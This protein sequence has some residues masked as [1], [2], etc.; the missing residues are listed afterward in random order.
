M[1]K[2]GLRA[3]AC[4]GAC[5][6][7]GAGSHYASRMC[8]RVP[9]TPLCSAQVAMARL[10]IKG[11]DYGPHAF[12]LPIRD[13]ATHEPLP[14]IDVGD[15]GPK[16]GY[17]GVDNGYVRPARAAR[18]SCGMRSAAGSMSTGAADRAERECLELSFATLRASSLIWPASYEGCRI[19]THSGCVKVADGALLEGVLSGCCSTPQI[20]GLGSCARQLMGVGGRAAEL[21]PRARPARVHADALCQ[22]APPARASNWGLGAGTGQRCPGRARGVPVLCGRFRVRHML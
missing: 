14:G 22:G 18:V 9:E 19:D 13:M 5:P 16:F 8:G 1:Q 6:G 4:R 20:L 12:V 10:F 11:R 3:R 17:N 2:R 15:I 21:R 7:A